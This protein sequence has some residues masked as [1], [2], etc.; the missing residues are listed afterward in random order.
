[1]KAFFATLDDLNFK[2]VL[3]TNNATKVASQYTEKLANFGVSM[4]PENIMTSAEVAA[5][6]IREQHPQTEDI[7]VVGESGLR[8]AVERQGFHII[9]PQQVK[10][11][12]YSSVVV[13]GFTR[14]LT[15]GEIAMACHLI[16]NGAK[17]YGTNG[18]VTF[19]TEMGPLPGAGSILAMIT[20]ATGVQPTITGKP[21]SIM[22]HQALK[23]MDSTVDETAM[24]GDRLNTDILGGQ[25]AG[26]ST[27]LLL[28][29][30]TKHADLETSEIQPDYVYNDITEL[31]SVLKEVHTV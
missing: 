10:D 23:R 16:H 17:Y 28:S 27:V 26:L 7:Y 6:Y 13:G 4:K 11:G 3:A 29:G 25:Q 30:V 20:T 12:A 15:Y 19:P 8:I 31:G 22:F 24:V 5:A 2:Y 1:L 14:D 9:T 18:D 21:K